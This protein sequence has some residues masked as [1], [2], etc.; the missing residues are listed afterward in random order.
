M[1][2]RLPRQVEALLS[3]MVVP[4]AG[5]SGLARS[6]Q[7]L[8][9]RATGRDLST[10]KQEDTHV[11]DGILRTSEHRGYLWERMERA[12]RVVFSQAKPGM[13]VGAEEEAQLRAC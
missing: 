10:G 11:A 3:L 1:L 9:T 13:A 2:L 8:L 7:G 4:L 6:D 5:A 12:D